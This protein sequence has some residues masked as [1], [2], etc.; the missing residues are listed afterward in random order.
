[1]CFNEE[2]AVVA[3]ATTTTMIIAFALIVAT[4]TLVTVVNHKCTENTNL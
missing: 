1:M 4:E 3:V 2:V